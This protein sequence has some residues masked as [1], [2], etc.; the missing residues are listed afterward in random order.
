[1]ENSHT[2]SLQYEKFSQNLL[3]TQQLHKNFNA[4]N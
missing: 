2:A 1:M 4:E 3:E